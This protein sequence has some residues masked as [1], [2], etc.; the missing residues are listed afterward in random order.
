MKI[1]EIKAL[2]EIMNETG[3]TSLNIV[4]DEITIHMEKQQPVAAAPAALPVAPAAPVAAA[5]PAAPAVEAAPV[6]FNNMKEIKSPM[7]GV[8]YTSP[9]PDADPFVTVGQK[10]KKGDVV[11]IIEAMKLLNEITSD[12][13][14]EIV[15]VCVNNGDVVEFNQPLFKIC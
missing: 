1:E 3:L 14:G 15:D 4:E 7:V 10:V 8:F 11:C 13:D 2:A 12:V 5:V 6:D 9:S